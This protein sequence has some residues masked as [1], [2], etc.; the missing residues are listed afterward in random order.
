MAES[1]RS[2]SSS[3]LGLLRGIAFLVLAVCALLQLFVFIL[4]WS[5]PQNRQQTRAR[6]LHCWC[7]IACWL[8][9]LRVRTAGSQPRAGLLVSN[10]LT[11]LDIIAYSSLQ[12]CIFVAKS[13]I[14]RWP[15]F[16][17][18][19]TAAGTIYVDRQRRT[20]SASGVRRIRQ[21]LADNLLV[22]LFPEGTSSGGENVLPF[23]SALLEAAADIDAPITAAAIQYCLAQGNVA[24]EIC[25]WGEMTL[26]P[27]LANL[28]TKRRI[29]S[30]VRFQRCHDLPVDRKNLAREL[31][32][33]V[34]ALLRA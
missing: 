9:G 6:W 22:V 19:T 18:L 23:K 32:A 16:G 31:H 17:W 20:A 12:P 10:H 3:A 25:Y 1:P 11:Y 8:I 34:S 14:A 30:R 7:R 28:F 5:R 21:A 24:A 4:P 33:Q 2:I 29:E 27:H 15:L 13:E 26:V